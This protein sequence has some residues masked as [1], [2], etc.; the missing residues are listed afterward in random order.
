MPTPPDSTAE[1]TA[2]LKRHEA[3]LL[4]LPGVS[5]CGIGLAAGGDRPVIQVFV[6]TA[7]ATADVTR[8]AARVL[9]SSA[10]AVV[11]M[12]PP[13]GDATRRPARDRTEEDD[14]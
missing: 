6:A 12:P 10:F 2:R 4:A 7:A 13:S 9:G 8:A 11:V 3:A 14:P 1:L 5:G